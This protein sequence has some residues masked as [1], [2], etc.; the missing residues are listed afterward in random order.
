M[1]RSLGVTLSAILSL[2]GSVLTLGLGIVA[3]LAM[4]IAPLPSAGN[5]PFPPGVLRA[6]LFFVV[7]LYVLPA[8][9]G[10]FTS[11][12]LFR[13][14]NWARISII[15][16]S[17]LL[18][19]MGGFSGL[20][21]LVIRN[22]PTPNKV[23]PS[24]VATARMVM[25]LF[26]LTVMS[27]GIWWAV[28]FNRAKVKAQFVQSAPTGTVSQISQTVP[29]QGAAATVQ[30]PLSI[31][32][33]AW[34]SLIGCLTFPFA[35]LLHTPAIFFTKILTGSPSVVLYLV[36]M[37]LNVY[38]AVGLLRLRETARRVGIAV[39][40]FG[41]VNSAVFYFAPGGSGRLRT[42]VEMQSS[43]FPWM[44]PWPGRQFA[45]FDPMP[46]M[47]VGTVVGLVA[48]LAPLYFLVTRKEAFQNAA[49]T[50][51]PGDIG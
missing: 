46:L 44:Q 15:V 50:P 39:Y 29:V 9:L 21:M 3:G 49:A 22:F 31:T 10:I 4:F 40:V 42:L 37:A 8:T 51:H 48:I 35:L 20:T 28:F 2:I 41:F 17:V 25:G 1:R 34:F 32:I 26:W 30:R 12:G 13:L 38:I 24:F 14:K 36:F 16:F 5:S 19:L 45:Q 47:I 43:L 11:I 6:I 27:I 23:D 7:L 18:I 33:L